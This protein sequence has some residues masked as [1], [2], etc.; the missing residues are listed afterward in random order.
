[1]WPIY[2]CFYIDC[3]EDLDLVS[4]KQSLSVGLTIGCPGED[5]KL[6]ASVQVVDILLRKLAKYLATFSSPQ[7]TKEDPA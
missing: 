2:S 7:T 3:R 4:A 5:S 6:T 1:M